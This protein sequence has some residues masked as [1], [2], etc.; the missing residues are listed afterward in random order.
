M[1][2]WQSRKFTI[3]DTK[4]NISYHKVGFRDFVGHMEK[5][6][7]T[8][9]DRWPTL[10]RFLTVRLQFFLVLFVWKWCMNHLHNDSVKVNIGKPYV[11][12]AFNLQQRSRSHIPSVS[13]KSQ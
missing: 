10:G 4:Q 9:I 11:W 12:Q 7:N 3:S 1:D 6:N 13:K 8:I 5:S 2:K